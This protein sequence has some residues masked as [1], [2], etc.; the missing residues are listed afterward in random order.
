M[1]LLQ[2]PNLVERILKR[3]RQRGWRRRR[4]NQRNSSAISRN[5]SQLGKPLAHR[6]PVVMRRGQVVAD[7]CGAVRHPT[8]E[9]VGLLGVTGKVCFYM[10]KNESENNN[11]L[12]R[13]RGEASAQAKLR[14]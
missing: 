10:A 14:A 11:P 13:R 4:R 1:E 2:A 3:L 12:D 8:R 6:Y 5:Q 7:G 9:Q